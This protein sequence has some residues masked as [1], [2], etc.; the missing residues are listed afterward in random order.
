MRTHGGIW[1]PGIHRSQKFCI[2]NARKGGRTKS[3]QVAFNIRSPE[4]LSQVM[5]GECLTLPVSLVKEFSPEALAIME[6]GSQRDI[7]IA[8]K[9]YERWPK[10]GEEAAGPPYRFYMREVAHGKR[11]SISLMKT[12]RDCLST[13]G[14]W[15]ICTTTGRRGIDRDEDEPRPGRSCPS[16]K[17]ASQF[18]LSGISLR[19]EYPTRRRKDQEIPDW[20]L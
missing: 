10:F 17:A 6:L 5:A 11:S 3:F 18:N 8:A 14:G 2:Y 4:Q 20:F 7:D 15:S 19:A 16:A 1:F 13:R 12:Q 9:M